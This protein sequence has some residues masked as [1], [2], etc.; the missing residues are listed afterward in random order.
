MTAGGAMVRT[1]E[2]VVMVRTAEAVVMVRT[3]EAVV[4]PRRLV[5]ADE[6]QHP[7]NLCGHVWGWHMPRACL[8]T[9]WSSELPPS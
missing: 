9:A 8:T 3:A 4:M 7:C 6:L 1:A 5:M 2:A